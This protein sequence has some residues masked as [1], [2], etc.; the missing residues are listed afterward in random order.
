MEAWS[1]SIE[2]EQPRLLHERF[3]IVT[4]TVAI[5][6]ERRRIPEEQST[7]QKER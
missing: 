4:R 5:H 6:H 7:F 1:F 3:G 2:K